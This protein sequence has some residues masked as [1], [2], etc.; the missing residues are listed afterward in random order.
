MTR[1]TVDPL[2]WL[3]KRL[4]EDGGDFVKDALEEFVQSLMHA[5]AQSV[6]KAG[7]GAV[8]AERENHRNGY[9]DRRWDTRCGTLMLRIPKL[10]RG[11]YF[12]HWLLEPRRRSEE[13]LMNAIAQ[14]YVEGVSTRRVEDLIQALGVENISK[15]Q[16][17]AISKRLDKV[18]ADFCNRPLANG[19]YRYVW[20]DA[21][22]IKVREG[23]RVANVACL[24]AT[25]V[26]RDGR[27][28]ILGTD[29]ITEE[30]GAGWLS[31]LRGLV[32]RGLSGVNLVTADAHQGIM[33][34]VQGALPGASWQRCRTH[35]MRNLL[36]RVPK[37]AQEAVAALVRSIFAQPDSDTV[38]E[39]HGRVVQQLADKF[40][41]ASELLEEAGPDVLAFTA[42]PKEH[43]RQIWSNNPQERLNR[44]IRRRTDVV[45]IFPGRESIL[46][47]V[48][49]VLS[50]LDD[51][52]SIGRR[53]FSLESLGKIDQHQQ[54][55]AL[56]CATTSKEKKKLKNAA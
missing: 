46:R 2:A 13:A 10:R 21:L 36:C 34:A 35:F 54:S 11:T 30:D 51:E 43:W 24:I 17:S 55:V 45:G 1:V 16:V 5:D 19:P 25:G 15:S 39:F 38:H 14:A 7:Y 42:F 29:L 3:S 32:A 48:G 47:L 6:C 31:F 40:P 9:R 41:K 22:A 4:C 26:N 50:E 23:G 49:A 44:E 28:E 52:W 27:R 12:P 56:P 18:V 37:N 53:Y 20:V 33:K 8:D